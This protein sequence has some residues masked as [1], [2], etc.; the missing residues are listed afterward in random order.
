MMTVVMDD[1][2][3]SI[4]GDIH[5]ERDIQAYTVDIQNVCIEALGLTIDLDCLDPKTKEK[6]LTKAEL[7]L[8]DQYEQVKTNPNRGF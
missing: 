5:F 8:I 6:L 3:I 7:K 1:C 4:H 2:E